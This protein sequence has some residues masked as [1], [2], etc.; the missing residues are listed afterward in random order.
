MPL[1]EITCKN[2]KTEMKLK[3]LAD[4]GG[5]H[6]LVK[7]TGSKLWRLAYRFHGK[8]KTISFGA[9][10]VVSL[11]EARKR[12]DA[13]KE[14]LANGI[15]PSADRKE[16]KAKALQSEEHTFKKVAMDWFENRR[17]S[18][19]AGYS[20]RLLRRME[21]DLFPSLGSRPI[22]EI[23]PPELLKVI[24]AIEE[25]GAI[26][27]AKRLLQIAGQVFRFAIACSIATRDPS[28][29]LRGAL[30]SSPPAKHRSALKAHELPEFL[31]RLNAYDGSRETILGLLLVM[32]TF[33]RTSEVRFGSWS[34]IEDLN[35]PS[36][37][38]RIPASRMKK[39]VEHIVPLTEE[40]V[41]ILK[42]LKERS[43][44]SPYIFPARTKSGVISE[45]TLIYALYRMGYHSRATVHGFR[46]TASTTLN[47]NGFNRDWI[48]RQLAHVERNDVRAAYN[49]AEYLP[50]RREMMK[51]WSSFIA[52]MNKKF[53]M[54]NAA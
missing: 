54:P 18:W 5:L 49:S 28:Q 7:P 52:N 39:R 15:D 27:M 21:S 13:A 16:R 32:H 53:Q 26:V 51:W 20:D 17:T 24:R 29:D 48:E 44:E 1:T 30:K 33:L 50:Q 11:K 23:E 43:G 6:L 41:Q 40:V 2:A 4:G 19:T 14:L 45:N 37:I 47:E 31:E 35:G 36:P 12:R 46:G 22:S 42:E 10:P 9:Y 8:Q 25:R 3:K 38:W 34:E